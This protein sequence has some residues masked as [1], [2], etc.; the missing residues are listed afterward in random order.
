MCG[1]VLSVD[2]VSADNMYSSVSGRV[3]R[4]SIVRVEPANYIVEL[5]PTV[6]LCT[7]MGT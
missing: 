6:I 2:S 3:Q 4:E 5:S 7:K 1:C